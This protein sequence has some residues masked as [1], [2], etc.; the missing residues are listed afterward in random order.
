MVAHR[1]VDP[2]VRVGAVV[3]GPRPPALREP[4][5]GLGLVGGDEHLGARDPPQ[6]RECEGACSR[7]AAE[8]R[9]VDDDAVAVVDQPLD[10]PL[11][12]AE[13]GGVL[14]VGVRGCHEKLAAQLIARNVRGMEPLREQPRAVCLP[15]PGE[16]HEHRDRRAPVRPRG[17]GHVGQ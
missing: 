16:A 12:D 3:L 2:L 13:D 10:Q 4:R 15:H 6:P 7:A 17:P 11:E 1:Q 14:G 9:R 5:E 8:M